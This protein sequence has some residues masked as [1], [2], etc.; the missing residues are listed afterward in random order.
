MGWSS[1]GCHESL[2]RKLVG[3]LQHNLQLVYALLLLC[4]MFMHI[5]QGDSEADLL[6]QMEIW[7]VVDEREDDLQIAEQ[8]LQELPKLSEMKGLSVLPTENS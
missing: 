6:S 3:V 8:V 2:L 1:Y 7:L 4:M 5:L